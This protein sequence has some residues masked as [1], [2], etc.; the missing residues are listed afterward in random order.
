ME[1][2]GGQGLE[3]FKRNDTLYVFKEK[4]KILWLGSH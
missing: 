1:S 3:L 4:R 2:D